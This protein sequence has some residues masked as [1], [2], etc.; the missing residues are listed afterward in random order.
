MVHDSHSAKPAHARELELKVEFDF[1]AAH[2]LPRHRGQCVNLHGHNYVLLVTVTGVPDASSG[3]IM[4]F[5]DVERVVKEHVLAK[6]DHKF[7][8]DFLEN[9]TAEHIV[10]WM[11]KELAPALPGLTELELFETPRYS[12]KLRRA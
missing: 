10:Q 8:N 4:D 2:R 12:C 6:C 1:S 9:P 3:F 7:L 11:W 5:D